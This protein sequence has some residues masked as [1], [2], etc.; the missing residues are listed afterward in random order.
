MSQVMLM[1]ASI[2]S[3]IRKAIAFPCF[4]VPIAFVT[5][6]PAHDLF[7]FELTQGAYSVAWLLWLVKYV[8]V[9]SY[10]IATPSRYYIM[11]H[12]KRG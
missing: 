6:L 11:A 3:E 1:K 7:P 2:N 10:H 9:L 8:L 12:S 4:L 5:V